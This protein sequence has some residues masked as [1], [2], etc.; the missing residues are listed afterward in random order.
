MTEFLK[1]MKSLTQARVDDIKES[2]ELLRNKAMDTAKPHDF[3]SIFNNKPTVIAEIKFSSPSKGKL[4][5]CSDPIATAN[6]YLTHG[7]SALSILTE[8]HYFNGSTSYLEKVRNSFPHAKLLMKDF[9]I[10][11]KQLLQARIL[12]ADAVLLIASFLSNSELKELY[13]LALSLD[14]TPLIEIHTEEEMSFV[15]TIN[16][17]LIGIN[18]R[19]LNTLKIDLDTS[20]RLIQFKTKNYF[21]ISESG[22]E[23]CEQLKQLSEL[24]YH[25][26]LIGSALMASNQPGT[27]LG[28]II[29]DAS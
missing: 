9:F 8:P 13:D 29:H 24:G 20:K 6:D 23:Q 19:N 14:L 17:S 10:S 22:L 18:N 7:A 28:R 5:A 16:P 21:L 12:G 2:V 15:E 3:L 25:G 27:A 4:T 26:F 11:E 1:H